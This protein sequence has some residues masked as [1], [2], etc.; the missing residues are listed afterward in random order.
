MIGPHVL[1]GTP[2]S[3]LWATRAPIVKSLHVNDLRDA[4]DGAVRVYRHYFP[5]QSLERDPADAAREIV[6]ALGGYAHRLLYAEIYNECF[7]TLGGPLEAYTAWTRLA[8]DE[9]HR[10]GVKAA[11]FSFSTGNPTAEA[12]AFLRSEGY[13]GAD[14]ISIREYWGNAGLSGW[15]AL[16]YRMVHAWTAGDHPP[17]LIG[18]C[19]RDAVEG[20]LGGWRRD[21]VAPET[22]LAEIAGYAQEVAKDVASGMALG[23]C[24]YAVGVTP[25][26]VHFEADDLVPGLM[27][28]PW[29]ALYDVG[30]GIREAIRADGYYE[31]DDEAYYLPGKLSVA[32]SVAADLTPGPLYFYSFASNGIYKLP[33]R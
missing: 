12:W 13:A 17:F 7:Q 24:L 23:A 22:Y 3:A 28:L 31:C 26:W 33:P 18:E 6:A 14:A 20:G 27:R 11:A 15:N 32:P 4:R 2:A 1:S 30:P 19:G 25:D 16:R 29:A 9:L 8:V 21:G 5:D 10:H